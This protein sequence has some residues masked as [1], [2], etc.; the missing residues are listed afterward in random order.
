M[1][2][3][4]PSAMPADYINASLV[5]SSG[6]N[7]LDISSENDYENHGQYQVYDY[8]SIEPSDEGVI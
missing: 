6:Q 1:M 4:T 5:V 3:A 2:A 7:E 8:N